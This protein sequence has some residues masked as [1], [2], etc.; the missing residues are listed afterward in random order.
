MVQSAPVISVGNLAMGGRGKTPVV[1]LITRWL[2]EAGERPSILSRGYGRRTAEPGVVIVSDGSHV[3]ADLDRSGDEPL[4]LARALPGAAV[5]VCDVR[6]TAAALAERALGCTVHVLDDGFQHPIRRDVDIV[7]VAPDDLTARRLPFGRLREPVTALARAAAVVIDD[8][9]A[10]DEA[11]AATVREIARVSPQARVFR[12]VRT[13]GQVLDFDAS[14]DSAPR[15][16]GFAQ[17]KPVIAVAGIANPERFARA[18]VD[19]GWIV[20]DLVAFPDH[21]RYRA[22]DIGRIADAARATNA[23]AILT[24]E[25]DGVRLRPLRPLRTPVPVG[26]VPLDVRIEPDL[27]PWLAERLAAVRERARA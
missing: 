26:I 27:Q 11:H 9:G 2:V 14:L 6:A 4:M 1:R 23:S 10:S 19:A 18:L 15:A 8:G 13:L 21:H 24:T 16:P 7:L 3:L 25:K 22:R 5:L 20:A 12:L 17:G